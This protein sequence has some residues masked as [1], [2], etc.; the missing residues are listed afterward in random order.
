MS[1]TFVLPP[2]LLRPILFLVCFS[3]S[4]LSHSMR[5]YC[6]NLYTAQLQRY[7]LK[8]SKWHTNNQI[9]YELFSQTSFSSHDLNQNFWPFLTL[10]HSVS[11]A[12][13]DFTCTLDMFHT[14]HLYFCSCDFFFAP[15][16]APFHPLNLFHPLTV[17]SKSTYS[18]ETFQISR[19]PLSPH[20]ANTFTQLTS[21]ALVFT[22]LTF[23]RL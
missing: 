14:F 1:L 7:I 11:S 8:C 4:V 3:I 21:T 6:I 10:Y 19:Y 5:C 23:P 16:P 22:S 17:Q 18:K 12:A 13:T 15:S 2:P 9:T 20:L